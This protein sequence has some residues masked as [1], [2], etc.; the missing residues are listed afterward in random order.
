MH[1][2]RV[3]THLSSMRKLLR[4][5]WYEV[6]SWQLACQRW[7][8]L[9]IGSKAGLVVCDGTMHHTTELWQLGDPDTAINMCV[10]LDCM[11][12]RQFQHQITFEHIIK[13]QELLFIIKIVIVCF[14]LTVVA[15]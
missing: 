10:Q 6:I 11:T 7:H 9:H 15:L 1:D 2:L 4:S 12:L 8:T 3:S 13:V 14:L 5:F